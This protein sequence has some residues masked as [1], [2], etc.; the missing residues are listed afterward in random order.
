MV[1]LELTPDFNA[2]RTSPFR[3]VPRGP[4][5]LSD[6]VS[7]PC[8]LISNLAAGLIRLTVEVCSDTLTTLFCGALSVECSSFC[9]P[10]KDV[11]AGILLIS[12]RSS[13]L[14]NGQPALSTKESLRYK[15]SH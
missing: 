1:E 2:A 9:S 3:R 7:S 14:Q 13:T 11:S 8:S 10:P 12:S 6:D 4:D 5:A 15:S